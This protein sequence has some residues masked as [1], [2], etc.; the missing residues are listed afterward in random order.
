M[1]QLMHRDYRCCAHYGHNG[2][3]TVPLSDGTFEAMFFMKVYSSL[4]S[5]SVFD[6][7]WYIVYFVPTRYL[8]L[9]KA[10]DFQLNTI[11]ITFRC[12]I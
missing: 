8:T 9:N 4:S 3:I 1:V 2:F 6:I 12:M 11:I 7:M 5:Q 10:M